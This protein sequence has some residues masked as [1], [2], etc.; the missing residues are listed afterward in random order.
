[1]YGTFSAKLKLCN[2][3]SAG[4]VTT[5]YVSDVTLADLCVFGDLYRGLALEFS[6]FKNVNLEG[7]PAP[8]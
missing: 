2:N 4:T 1:M 8:H 6:C 3:D 7:D 5:F